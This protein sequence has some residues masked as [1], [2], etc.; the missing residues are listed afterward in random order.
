MLKGLLYFL[1]CVSSLIHVPGVVARPEWVVIL[2]WI[3]SVSY[4]VMALVAVTECRRLRRWLR[5]RFK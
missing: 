3:G 4:L 1:E 2:A 5:K